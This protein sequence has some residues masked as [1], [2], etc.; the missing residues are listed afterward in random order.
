MCNAY[1]VQAKVGAKELTEVISR[2]IRQLPSPLVRRCGPGVV[3][4]GQ[5][6]ELKPQIMR[7]AFEHPKYK[8]V[9]NARATSLKSPYWAESLQERRC[10]VPIS[11]FYEWE[12]APSGRAKKCYE[13]RRPDGE[14]MWIAG[15]YQSFTSHG[16]CYATITTDPTPAVAAVHDRMLAVLDWGAALAFLAKDF[17]P[18]APYDG[19]IVI[20]PCESPLKHQRDFGQGELF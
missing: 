16:N 18:S 11:R 1:N 15:I 14:W 8:A 13:F 2:V 4:T 3:I 9:N 20:S 12:E 17:T 7:W 10:I 6:D 5:V 19:E